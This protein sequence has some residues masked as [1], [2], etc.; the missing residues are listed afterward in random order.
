MGLFKSIG[1]ETSGSSG[2]IIKVKD[3]TLNKNENGL[4]V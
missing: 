4:V 3:T 1:G 2:K